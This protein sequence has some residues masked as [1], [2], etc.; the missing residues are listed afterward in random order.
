MTQ[1]R[2]A[3]FPITAFDNLNESR[4]A[5]LGISD[6][7]HDAC[8]LF[9]LHQGQVLMIVDGTSHYLESDQCIWICCSH[10]IFYKP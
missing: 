9:M 10:Y 1:H 3:A 4:P 5:K 7:H 8:E 2:N 6:H